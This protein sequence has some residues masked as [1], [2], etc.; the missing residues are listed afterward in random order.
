MEPSYLWSSIQTALD[1]SNVSGVL[2][3]EANVEGVMETWNSQSGYPVVNVERN[4]EDG[5]VTFSQVIKTKQKLKNS[6]NISF[7]DVLFFPM[8]HMTTAKFIR[9]QLTLQQVLIQILRT[10][11]QRCG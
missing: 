8:P 1:S 3:S 10:P 5:S 4:Y 6:K 7:R 2:P 11:S 9:S